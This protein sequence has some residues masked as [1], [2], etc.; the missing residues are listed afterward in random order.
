MQHT[1]QQSRCHESRELETRSRAAR[2]V[3]PPVDSTVVRLTNVVHTMCEMRTD[4]GTQRRGGATPDRAMDRADAR[5]ARRRS[6]DGSSSHEPWCNM[7]ERGGTFRG[8]RLN[9]NPIRTHACV[10]PQAAA[11]A[12]R[13][14]RGGRRDV[15]RVK[16]ISRECERAAGLPPASG[17]TC[18]RPRECGSECAAAPP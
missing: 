3:A 8:S 6:L 16:L 7:T 9:P 18:R 14:V 4:S 5:R 17:L 13:H 12:G 10:S 15:C 2:T 11:C 1:S